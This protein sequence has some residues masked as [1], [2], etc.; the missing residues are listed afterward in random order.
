MYAYIYEGL[1]HGPGDVVGQRD[2][3]H[4][5]PP[6]SEASEWVLQVLEQGQ[7]LELLG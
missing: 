5:T 6:T 2:G 1:V 7:L 3:G 4:M